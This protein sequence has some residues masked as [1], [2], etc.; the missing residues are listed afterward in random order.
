MKLIGITELVQSY[1]QLLADKPLKVWA[2]PVNPNM[3]P[4]GIHGVP[5]STIDTATAESE[6][7]VGWGFGMGASWLLFEKQEDAL[8]ASVSFGE[9][10]V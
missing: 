4:G 5:L 7:W 9:I 8:M 6:G 3:E 2:V 1:S 10:H